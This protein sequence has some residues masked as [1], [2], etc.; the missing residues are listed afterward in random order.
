[1][2]MGRLLLYPSHDKWYKPT[3]TIISIYWFIGLVLIVAD[4]AGVVEWYTHRT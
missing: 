4:F 3:A 2:T 1:M